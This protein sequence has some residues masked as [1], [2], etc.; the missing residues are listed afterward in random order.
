ME[1]GLRW[2]KKVLHANSD[3]INV[4]RY[5]KQDRAL[6]PNSL[7]TRYERPEYHRLDRNGSVPGIIC[8]EG[9]GTVEKQDEN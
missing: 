5:P 6:T 3:L 4:P 7:N 2:P 8:V 9:A 1:G